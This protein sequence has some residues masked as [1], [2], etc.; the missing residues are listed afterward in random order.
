MANLTY[1]NYPGVGEENKKHYYY[2][3]AVRIGDQIECSG[4]GNPPPTP[5]LPSPNIP[6]R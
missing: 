2:S 4:Q 3:Q 5:L 6:T 1:Y